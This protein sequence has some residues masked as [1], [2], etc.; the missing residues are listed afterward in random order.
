MAVKLRALASAVILLFASGCATGYSTKNS[1]I[2][3]FGGQKIERIDKN[4]WL[5]VAIANGF[6]RHNAGQNIALYKAALITRAAGYEYFQI[7]SFEIFSIGNLEGQTGTM[8]IHT[9]NN[10]FAP[11]ECEAWRFRPN[12]RVLNA[13]RTMKRYGAL[14][15]RS[16]EQGAEEVAKLREQ[17]GLPDAENLA[18]PE[19][20]GP[21]SQST[22]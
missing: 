16:P 20:R 14:I 4:S 21:P 15:G 6:S 11:F 9:V 5:I 12:C 10:P 2:G 1:G 22:T 19:N 7:Y 8:K 18:P 13:E 17:H 3:L